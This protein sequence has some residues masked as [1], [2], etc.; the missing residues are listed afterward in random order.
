MV[1][2]LDHMMAETNDLLAA[3]R[4]YLAEHEPCAHSYEKAD[5]DSFTPRAIEDALL[6]S[7]ET[8]RLVARLMQVMAWLLAQRATM[9]GETS[10]GGK[11]A[12]PALGGQVLCGRT[13]DSVTLPDDLMAL[14]RRSHA[15]YKRTARLANRMNMQTAGVAARNPA[16]F[17]HVALRS[18]KPL[19]FA[20][21]P[22]KRR[23]KVH[24]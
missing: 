8:T 23:R 10:A 11:V 7:M 12:A 24:R 5:Q 19:P 16:A 3:T 17:V 2:F 20:S 6:V 9:A 13:E 21:V 18:D 1:R 15:L 22:A 14:M 4:A